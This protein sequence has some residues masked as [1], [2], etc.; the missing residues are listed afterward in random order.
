MEILQK[1]KN[2]TII[3]AVK[4]WDEMTEEE[5][6]SIVHTHE[7]YDTFTI[8]RNKKGEIINVYGRDFT[9]AKKKEI[10]DSRGE[11]DEL[12]RDYAYISG[13]IPIKVYAA[14]IGIDPATIRQKIARGGVPQAVKLGR[15]WLVP[16]D[17]VWTDGRRK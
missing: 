7:D 2:G 10:E 9:A 14:K 8:M 15:D 17:M 13:L 4:T 5:R 1:A 16:R 11:M 6:E 3:G 12:R